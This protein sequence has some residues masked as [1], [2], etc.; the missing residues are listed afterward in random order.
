MKNFLEDVRMNPGIVYRGLA[1]NLSS[2]VPITGLQVGL[3]RLIS[4]KIQNNSTD[5]TLYQ[6]LLSSTASGVIA[7]FIA[8]PTENIMTF[9]KQVGA[10]PL[11]AMTMKYTQ[12]SVYGFAKGFAGTALRD[13]IFVSFYRALVPCAKER[14]TPHVPNDFVA[15]IMAGSPIGVLAAYLSHPLDTIKTKQQT[16]K[17]P[18]GF[19]AT[20]K[21]IYGQLGL[22]GFFSGSVAR[23]GRVAIAIPV[24][25]KATEVVENALVGAPEL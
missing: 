7:S 22:R 10:K 9:Q 1:A 21:G 25:T 3:D 6:R 16:S 23:A 18:Q 19:V 4:S 5:P 15:T 8:T 20:T 24:M 17:N 2:M 14:I 13:G 11:A 12:E